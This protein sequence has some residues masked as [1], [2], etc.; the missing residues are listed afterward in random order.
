M[1]TSTENQDPHLQAVLARECDNTA[2][3][4]RILHSGKIGPD[5]AWKVEMER[6]LEGPEETPIWLIRISLVDA[7]GRILRGPKTYERVGDPHLN[8]TNVPFNP[9]DTSWDFQLYAG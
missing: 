5:D 4:L 2:S 1:K 8:R 9:C 7:V 6:R 3:G